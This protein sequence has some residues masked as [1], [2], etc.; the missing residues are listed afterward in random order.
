M[1]QKRQD[2]VHNL[3]RVEESYRVFEVAKEAV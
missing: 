2:Q 3:K 1:R